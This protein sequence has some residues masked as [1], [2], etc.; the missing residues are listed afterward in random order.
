MLKRQKK[1]FFDCLQ[2]S[3]LQYQKYALLLPFAFCLCQNNKTSAKGFIFMFSTYVCQKTKSSGFD[4][5]T[6]L[7]ERLFYAVLPFD[8]VFSQSLCSDPTG[9]TT[10]RPGGLYKLRDNSEITPR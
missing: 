3:V 8:Y 9:G 5:L 1:L 10:N 6:C 2:T 4:F 7:V